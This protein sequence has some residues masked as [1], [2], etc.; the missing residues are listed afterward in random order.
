MT[1]FLTEQETEQEQGEN[2]R[3]C[4]NCE[5]WDQNTA[6]E[7]SGL[8]RVNAPVIANYGKWPR[9]NATDW[10]SKFTPSEQYKA[11]KD[12]ETLEQ[13]ALEQNK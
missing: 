7:W 3:E 6:L 8:C 4:R 2:M 10:C 13:F 5:W 12:K 9:S 11:Q 1:Y